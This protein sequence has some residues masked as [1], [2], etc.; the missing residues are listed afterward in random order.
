[1][2]WIFRVNA[3]LDADMIRAAL[4]HVLETGD[5]RKLAGT[6]HRNVSK[7]CVGAL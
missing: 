4:Q 5:W 3:P 2:G 7:A 6:L 1:M